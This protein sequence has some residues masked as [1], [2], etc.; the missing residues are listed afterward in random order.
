MTIAS[1][2]VSKT[3]LGHNNGCC[4][5]L[6]PWRGGPGCL[7]PLQDVLKLSKWVSFTNGLYT[8]ISSVSVLVSRLGESVMGSLR[9]GFSFSEILWFSWAYS[10]FVLKASEARYYGISSRLCWIY[11]LGCFIWSSDLPHPHL[12]QSSGL[13]RSLLALKCGSW[14][15]IYSSAGLYFC[16]FHPCQCCL[17]L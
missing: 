2:C 3:K 8:F 17:L 6:S 13:F 15:V 14:G 4:Q 12:Q 7:L 11:G 9:L 10:L 1:L 16:L 5:C